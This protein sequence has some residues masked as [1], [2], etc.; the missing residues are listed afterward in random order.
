MA[1][2]YLD[3]SSKKW[4]VYALG[5]A[6]DTA[7]EV[8]SAREWATKTDRTQPKFKY[9]AL[10]NWLILDGKLAEAKAAIEKSR[11]LAS[12]PAPDNEI[13]QKLASIG[14]RDA[15][16]AFRQDTRSSDTA[17]EQALPQYEAFIGAVSPQAP[18]TQK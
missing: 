12:K 7:R 17:L 5:P 6:A 1:V 13:A 9:R 15:A 8:A 16:E 14:A 18:T 2:A 10:A 3:Q 11:Q 4:R